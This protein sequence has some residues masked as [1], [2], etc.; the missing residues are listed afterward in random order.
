[1]GTDFPVEDIDP[2]K[3]FISA[4]FRQ[5]QK[6]WPAIGFQKEN[7]LSREAALRGMTIWAAQSNFEENEK[8]SIEVG[9]MADFV[10][11]NVDLMQASFEQLLSA[12]VIQTICAGEVVYKKN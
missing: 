11:L 7:A 12:K 3:T 5:D 6:G 1:L 9:K 10:V 8:G 2:L 4:V